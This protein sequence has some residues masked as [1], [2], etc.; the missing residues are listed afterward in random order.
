MDDEVDRDLQRNKLDKYKYR[1]I[2][3]EPDLRDIIDLF[4]Y[5]DLIDMTPGLILT[6]QK[7]KLVR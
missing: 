2:F 6:E 3:D 7:R 4:R 1:P 5:R